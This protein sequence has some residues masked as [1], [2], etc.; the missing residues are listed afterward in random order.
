MIRKI[1]IIFQKKNTMNKLILLRY[2]GVKNKWFH[3]LKYFY[4]RFSVNMGP[5]EIFK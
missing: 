4:K 5:S 1:K 2:N 3:I